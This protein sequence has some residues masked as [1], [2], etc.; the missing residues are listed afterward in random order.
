MGRNRLILQ[1]L[2][3][4]AVFKMLTKSSA[5]VCTCFFSHCVLCIRGIGSCAQKPPCRIW[6]NLSIKM[7]T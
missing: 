2:A 1:Q 3:E 5:L 7:C 6:I 4:V